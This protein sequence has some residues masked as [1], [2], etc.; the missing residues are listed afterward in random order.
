[1]K[2]PVRLSISLLAT[3]ASA[4]ASAHHSRTAIFTDEE[5]EVTGV[6]TR[7]LYRNPHA[8][9][10]LDV[11]GEDGAVTAWRAEGGAANLLRERGWARDEIKPGDLVRITGD[12]SRNG[13][14]MISMGE[15][16]I[17]DPE[18][19]SVLRIAGDAPLPD[20]RQAV[21]ALSLKLADGRPNLSGA[22]TERPPGVRSGMGGGMG[23]GGM[24]GGDR[25]G[26]PSFNETGAA[27][28][29]QFDAVND[30][31]LYCK[32]VGLVRQAGFTPHP[33]RIEQD[34][35]IV[36]I[37]YE[38]YGGVRT[39]EIDGVRPE[40]G[41]LSHF[42][43]Y[44]AY[45]DDDALV[46]ESINLLGNLASPRGYALSDQT[47]VVETYRRN[48]DPAR[49]PAL[50]LETVVTDPGHLDAPWTLTWTKYY[51]ENYEFIPNDC[52][53]PLQPEE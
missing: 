30:P 26:T 23:G 9:I 42:G 7:F 1:M 21:A 49:G 48:D 24:G 35:D 17:L 4:A 6:V 2:I 16:A 46:I 3:L 50:T 53:P 18:D 31:A 41:A 15:V 28:Q 44:Y 36:V 33:V 22:W 37:S 20:Q 10:Y 32:P 45:Y 5:I 51:W 13:S 38:E 25:R 52:Q 47:S 12:S 40:P 8:M 27:L 11:T 29:A 19:G 39:I 14:P 43:E 34:G